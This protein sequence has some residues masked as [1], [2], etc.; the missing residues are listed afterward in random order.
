MERGAIVEH[1]NHDELLAR[2]RAYSDLYNSQFVA[3]LAEAV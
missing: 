2:R 1:G 3:A